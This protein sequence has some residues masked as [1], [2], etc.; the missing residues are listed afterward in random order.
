MIVFACWQKVSSQIKDWFYSE[1]N[2]QSLE[3]FIRLSAL[4]VQYFVFGD[5]F[6]EYFCYT[7]GL[8]CDEHCQFF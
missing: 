2:S 7:L 8:N 5:I 4:L 6:K 3:M 1:V